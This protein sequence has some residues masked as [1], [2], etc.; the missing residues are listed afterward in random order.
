VRRAQRH[1]LRA[2][3][4]VNLTRARFVA[5]TFPVRL[6]GTQVLVLVGTIVTSAILLWAH[7][8]RVHGEPR[9]LARIFYFLFAYADYSGAICALLVILGAVL[10]ARVVPARSV[11]QWSGSHPLGVAAVTAIVLAIGTLVAYHNHPLS[12]DEYAAYFQ[13]QVFAAGHLSGS[14]PPQLLDWLVPRGFQD[15]FLNVSRANGDVAESYWPGFALLLAPFT[16]LGIPW[17]CNPIV[18]ALTLIVIHRV[19]VRLP[20]SGRTRAASDG[21]LP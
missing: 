7:Q 9:G 20:R 2:R 5:N 19:R 11:L 8:M 16:R 15:Y 12:M 4:A 1:L 17:A 13:S 10:L 18:S 3:L 14:F 21:C 6:T